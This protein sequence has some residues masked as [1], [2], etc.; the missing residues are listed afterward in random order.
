MN[1]KDLH[2]D[3]QFI[4]GALNLSHST[5]YY[6]KKELI[7]FYNRYIKDIYPKEE[8]IKENK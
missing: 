2:K 1:I 5:S 4:K 7:E 6:N 8:F 3:A